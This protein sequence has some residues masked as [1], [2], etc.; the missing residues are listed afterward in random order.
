MPVVLYFKNICCQN[1]T[2][3]KLFA[4]RPT[5]AIAVLNREYNASQLITYLV[6]SSQRRKS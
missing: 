3:S 5:L 2:Q 6:F 4:S 1:P